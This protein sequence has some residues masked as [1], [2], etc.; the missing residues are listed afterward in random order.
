MTDIMCRHLDPHRF[1]GM[2][3]CLSCGEVVNE[4][5]ASSST[6]HIHA[7][8]ATALYKHKRLDYEFGHEI[9]LV[10]L[11]LG[12][13][14]DPIRCKVIHVSLV[15]DPLYDAVSFTWA[16][17]NR[18]A[19]LCMAIPYEQGGIIPVTA[20]CYAA[21]VQLKR[22]DSKRKVW[23]DAICMDKLKHTP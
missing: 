13:S 11:L 15:E 19:S 10:V 5:E 12:S 6:A 8:N 22:L 9:Q 7:N 17:E 23:V 18:D 21:L 20:N 1:D 3:C 2:I 14:E 4:L 16:T